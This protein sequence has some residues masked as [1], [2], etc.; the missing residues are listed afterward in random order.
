MDWSSRLRHIAFVSATVVSFQTLVTTILLVFRV[1]WLIFVSAGT[2]L[3]LAWYL[4][5]VYHDHLYGRDYSKP[6][7]TDWDAVFAS[8]YMLAA[9]EA[10]YVTK[11][12]TVGILAAVV[13]FF[14]L[15]FV[16]QEERC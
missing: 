14:L 8:A 15:G 9:A 5:K 12:L 11:M 7:F 4:L 10:I 13:V 16:Y 6:V 1:E 3:A 2:A